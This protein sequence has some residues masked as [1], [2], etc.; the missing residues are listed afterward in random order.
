MKLLG[1]RPARR[2]PGRIRSRIVIKRAAAVAAVLFSTSAQLS[3]SGLRTKLGEF[4]VRG[5]KIG[6]QYSLSQLVNL[7]LRVVNIGGESERVLIDVVPMDKS[8]VGGAQ[9]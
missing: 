8:A 9:P 2:T 1:A 3:A 5:L 4:E 7:P 6:Q